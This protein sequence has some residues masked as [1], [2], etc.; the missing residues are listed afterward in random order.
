VAFDGGREELQSVLRTIDNVR[1]QTQQDAAVYKRRM[2]EQCQSMQ[3]VVENFH[4][5]SARLVGQLD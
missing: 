2:R 5:A 4:S 3:A 1:E